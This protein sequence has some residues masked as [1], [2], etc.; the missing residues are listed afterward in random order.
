M[1]DV[2]PTFLFTASI[3]PPAGLQVVEIYFDTAT[4]DV[5]ERDLKVTVEFNLKYFGCA[6]I[7]LLIKTIM[8]STLKNTIVLEKCSTF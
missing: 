7:V 4:Y 5:I 6:Q 2:S 3:I 8:P 1:Y